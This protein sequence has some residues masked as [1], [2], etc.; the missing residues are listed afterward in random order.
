[1]QQQYWNSMVQY[2]FAINY[3]K[4]RLDQYTR[5]NI[6]SKVLIALATVGTVSSWAIWK[7]FS[8]L[9]PIVVVILQVAQVAKDF[10]PYQARVDELSKMHPA[11]YKLFANIQAKWNEIENG[12]LKVSEISALENTFSEDWLKIEM[13]YFNKVNLPER[14]SAIYR[15]N[16]ITDLMFESKLDQEGKDQLAK[17]KMSYFEAL[18]KQYGLSKKGIPLTRNAPPKLYSIP[19]PPVKP[20]KPE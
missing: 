15:A 5:T 6:I 14:F 2:A 9:L 17:S 8:W 18:K 12:S 19:M 20:A 3:Y 10:L 13:D 1:M 16:N 11:L 7:S 4:Y